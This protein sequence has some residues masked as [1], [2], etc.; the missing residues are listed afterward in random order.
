MEKAN[1]L[2][3]ES[4]LSIGFFGIQQ[5]KLTANSFQRLITRRKNAIDSEQMNGSYCSDKRMFWGT[6]FPANLNRREDAAA[7]KEV[8]AEDEVDRVVD[9]FSEHRKTA[10]DDRLAAVDED[11]HHV[12][13]NSH[14]HQSVPKTDPDT[15]LHLLTTNARSDQ[16][17][18]DDEFS[19]DAEDKRA[20]N[21]LTLLQTEIQTMNAENQRLKGMLS[22][23]S[24]SYTALQMH[25]RALMQ[26]K[27]EANN[28]KEHEVVQVEAQDKKH[29]QLDNIL[30]RQ[31]VDSECPNGGMAVTQ[32]SSKTSSNKRT[33]GCL[34]LP[35][36]INETAAFNNEKDGKVIRI[37]KSSGLENPGWNPNK[38]LDLKNPNAMDQTTESTMKKARVLVRTRSE[39]PMIS[40]GCHWRKYG[41]KMAKGNPCPRAYYRCT[42][43]VGCPVRK[44]VQRC[45]NDRSI[46]MTTYEGSH[47]HPLPPAAMAMASTTAAAANML[48][49]GSISSAD[50][51]MNPNFL[52]RTILPCS[53]SMATI[54]ASAPFP[55]V[56][57]DLTHQQNVPYASQLPY[58]FGS[59][60]HNFGSLAHQSQLPQILGQALINQSTFSGPQRSQEQPQGP[61]QPPQLHQSQHA[62]HADTLSAA[63]AAIASDPNFTA[64]LAAAISSI[65]SGSHPNCATAAATTTNS[66]AATAI[67]VMGRSAPGSSNLA[68]VIGLLVSRGAIGEP[69][70]LHPTI[71]NLWQPETQS[72]RTNRARKKPLHVLEHSDQYAS[73]HSPWAPV[74]E[75]RLSGA[76]KRRNEWTPNGSAAACAW[77][78]LVLVLL[79]AIITAT[80]FWNSEGFWSSVRLRTG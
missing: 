77:N 19:S 66:A 80:K 51:I 44:H 32:E 36:D 43:A 57:L 39:S 26:K 58:N 79:G 52:A 61:P 17:T 16:S 49:S 23:V 59:L 20:K 40:D 62:S 54:S 42:M 47:N 2:A 6:E 37:E 31:F 12:M 46:L 56:T 55:T 21:E 50:G 15:G 10:R 38:V 70:D 33:L 27:Q 28:T 14:D 8:A 53:S 64:A 45:A 4:D 73:D 7:G 48:L 11:D 3:V 76:T 74:R 63:T 9:F 78:S 65:L 34:G 22:Q 35:G 75:R 41:Q 24:S 67:A 1:G 71:N 5:N 60:P 18:V 13:E 30:P 69:M 25:L 29:E 68:P 72:S